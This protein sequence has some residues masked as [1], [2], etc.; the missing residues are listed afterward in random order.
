[1]ERGESC[2]FAISKPETCMAQ[3]NQ[4]KN[5]KAFEYAIAKVYCEHINQQGVNAVLVE[6]EACAQARGYYE[7]C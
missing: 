2:T 6:N 3:G 7:E 1:M 5:G 4:I